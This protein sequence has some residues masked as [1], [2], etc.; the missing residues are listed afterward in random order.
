[1]RTIPDGTSRQRRDP[2]LS[3]RDQF[4]FQKPDIGP[5]Q[6]SWTLSRLYWKPS[7]FLNADFTRTND[8]LHPPQTDLGPGAI[9]GMLLLTAAQWTSRRDA[10]TI[11]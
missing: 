4:S 9:L 11:G 3:F 5:N 6:N 8:G 2:L 1:M 10:N 7:A